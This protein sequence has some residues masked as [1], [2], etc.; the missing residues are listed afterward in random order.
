MYIN[1][2]GLLAGLCWNH[3]NGNFQPVSTQQ[4]VHSTGSLFT[5]LSQPHQTKNRWI[6]Y[7]GAQSRFFHKAQG[8]NCNAF[9]PSELQLSTLGWY[10]TTPFKHNCA[11]Q[12][13]CEYLLNGPRFIKDAGL[14]RQKS[15]QLAMDRTQ[16]A[17]SILLC[18]GKKKEKKKLGFKRS[19]A[20]KCLNIKKKKKLCTKNNGG[21][22]NKRNLSRPLPYKANKKGPRA[23]WK[24]ANVCAP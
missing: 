19:E 15:P 5:H 3:L 2:N 10:S 16:S 13:A 4:R 22:G 8:R 24:E 20:I 6:Y 17:K 11:Q 1:G 23:A 18:G 21:E 12:G 7:L 14:T 9:R